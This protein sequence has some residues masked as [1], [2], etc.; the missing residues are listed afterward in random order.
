MIESYVARLALLRSQLCLDL[1]FSTEKRKK[2]ALW[3]G[4][5]IGVYKRDNSAF[6]GREG[7]KRY[8]QWWW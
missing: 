8:A 4:L 2:R 3:G 7:E 6:V 5:V 1:R